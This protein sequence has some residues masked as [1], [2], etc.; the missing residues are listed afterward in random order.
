MRY[1]HKPGHLRWRRN[2]ADVRYLRAVP[3]GADAGS[4]NLRVHLLHNLPVW[5]NTRFN[6]LRMLRASSDQNRVWYCKL[7]QC[8]R[9]LRRYGFLWHVHCP[10][11]VQRLSG[12]LWLHPRISCGCLR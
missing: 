9:W 1:L 3:V 4:D 2:T 7:R 6:D 12:H 5:A 10:R 11:H 8:A